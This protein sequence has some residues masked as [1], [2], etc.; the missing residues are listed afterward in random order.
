[1]KNKET[2]LSGGQ[3]TDS[4]V[5]IGNRVHRTKSDNYEFIHSVLL[6]LEKQ[7]FTYAPKFLGIDEKGREMLSYLEGEVPRDVPMSF[8]QKITAVKILRSFH[9]ILADSQFCGNQET[10]CHQDFAPW[11]IIIHKDKIAGIID[12]DEVALGRRI[13]DLTYFI[14]TALDLGI[15]SITDDQQIEKIALLVNAYQLSGKNEIISS[16]LKQQNRILKFRKQVVAE[17]KNLDKV[18]FSKVAITRIEQSIAW[19]NQYQN[20]ILAAI[21]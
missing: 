4:V 18:T 9:D 3:C 14:W 17:D 19:I 6:F 11:N 13:D 5:R 15:A 21:K 2:I 20:K 10:V 7:N 8:S 16:F 12:F 1:M